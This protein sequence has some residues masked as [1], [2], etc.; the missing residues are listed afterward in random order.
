[1][2]SLTEKLCETTIIELL[3]ENEVVT[4]HIH[5]EFINHLKGE[6]INE[7]RRDNEVNSKWRKNRCRI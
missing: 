3:D 1:M 4:M 7:I 2:K 6:K 5:N